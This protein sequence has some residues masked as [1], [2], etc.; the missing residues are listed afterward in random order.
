[1]GSSKKDHKVEIRTTDG[2][3]KT[4]RVTEDDARYYDTLPFTST[5]VSSTTIT[6]EQS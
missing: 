2:D 1:M 3:V 6:R 4:V 5:N